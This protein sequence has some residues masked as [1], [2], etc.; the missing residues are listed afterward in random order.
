MEQSDTQQ[1]PRRIAKVALASGLSTTLSIVLQLIAVPICLAYW[2]Q[3]QYGQWLTLYAAFLVIRSLDSGYIGYVGNKLNILYHEDAEALRTHLGSAAVGVVVL[4]G[5]QLSL[6]VGVVQF[7]VLANHLGVQALAT[8]HRTG[9]LGL[10]LMTVSWV[11]TG[12]YLGIV[13]RLAIPTRLMYEAAWWSMAFQIF[14]AGALMAA[15]VMRLG[16]LQTS[17]LFAGSQA[18][19]YVIS[20]LYFRRRL[21]EFVPWLQGLNI[22]RGLSDLAHALVPTASNMVQQGQNSGMVLMVS[23]LVGPAAIPVYTTLRTLSNLWT[24]VTNAIAAPLLP[25]IVRF[26]VHRDADKLAATEEA[27]GAVAGTLVNFGILFAYPLLPWVYT[28]WTRGTLALNHELLCLMLAGVAVVN[29]GALREVYLTG[30]NKTGAILAT[31]TVRL[32]S[33][34]G[35]G[36]ALYG[37]M[38]LVSFGLGLL[39][40]EIL[41]VIV[42]SLVA[43]RTSSWGR[44]PPSTWGAAVVVSFLSIEGFHLAT[45]HWLWPAAVLALA[46]SSASSWWRLDEALRA[47]ILR[48][49]RMH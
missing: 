1:L 48:P 32:T 12:S 2:G 20:A 28:L 33:S 9:L 16:L 45:S 29:A 19:A 41:A 31:A 34:L 35:I 46:A 13:H 47:R 42:T 14:T 49:F 11:L 26:H 44:I 10:L 6:A 17:A 4:G 30:I 8:D 15:A 25:E 37:S 24:N 36:W 38:G 21:P 7:D 3:L 18:L 23:S 39:T 5:L 40:G 27:Y 43:H 22:Q